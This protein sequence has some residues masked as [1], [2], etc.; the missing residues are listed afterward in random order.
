MKQPLQQR[1]TDCLG[2]GVG[3]GE[4]DVP[5]GVILQDEVVHVAHDPHNVIPG[6]IIVQTMRHL[7]SAHE[8]SAREHEHIWRVVHRVRSVMAGEL[9][10]PR[11]LTYQDDATRGHFHVWILPLY[12]EM[13]E[14]GHGP[15]R[16]LPFLQQTK[17]TWDTEQHRQ[18][19][20]RIASALRQA[21]AGVTS[22]HE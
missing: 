14:L 7:T 17:Q 6:F 4:V 21:L 19:I 5:G 16:I 11:A 18:R 13:K 15:E 12:P 1:S 2:C 9:A 8:L 22:D 3:S 20:D 10:L